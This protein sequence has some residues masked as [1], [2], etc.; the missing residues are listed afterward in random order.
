MSLFLQANILLGLRVILKENSEKSMQALTDSMISMM[1]AGNIIKHS[2]NNEEVTKLL[3]LIECDIA[4]S[5]YDLRVRKNYLW[6][7][8]QNYC[9][10]KRK[11]MSSLTRNLKIIIFIC[12]FAVINRNI[13]IHFSGLITP[14][15]ESIDWPTP[16]LSYCSPEL[17]SPI[18]FLYFYTF[19][20]LTVSIYFTEAFLIV[21]LVTLSIERLLADFDILIILLDDLI[22]VSLEPGLNAD[23]NNSSQAI[24]QQNNIS[25]FTEKPVHLREDMA[26][27]VHHHQ[28]LYRNF[29][30]CADGSGYMISIINIE[31]MIYCCTMAYL[32]LT[33][34]D[35]RKRMIFALSFVLVSLTIFYAY[36][37]GQRILNQN[38]ILRRKLAEIHWTDKPHWFKQ[39][40]HI[41]MTRANVD[42]QMR[43]FGIYTLN[44][45]S[46][47]DL[48]KSTYSIGNILYTRKMASDNMETIII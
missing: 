31:I 39:T 18:F 36:H 1:M 26:H 16:L 25:H 4:S 30:L 33:T 9:R 3:E 7:K 37:N 10:E 15:N 41:M 5:H 14:E 24:D 13:I 43:P 27:I 48:M 23:S 32:V 12:G 35:L 44:Y 34:N 22:Q 8:I 20:S 42:I 6:R 2:I 21:F 40:L 28:T 45:V 47:K 17:K 38:D 46:F 29:R 11:D 19:H